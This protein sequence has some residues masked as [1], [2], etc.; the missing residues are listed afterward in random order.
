MAGG[1]SFRWHSAARSAS[2]LAL[3]KFGETP[4]ETSLIRE[5]VFKFKQPAFKTTEEFVRLVKEAEVKNINPERLRII[6]HEVVTYPKKETE[7]TKSHMVAED[8]GAAKRVGKTGVMV[9][10]VLTLIC[11]HPQH[12]DFGINVSYSQRYYPAQRDP[13]FLEK[14]T[15][16]FDSVDF[17]EF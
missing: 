11:I 17:V 3:G 12:K 4:E 6:K 15:T 8:H 2:Q 10:E 14:A 5:I 13:R 7:C 9:Q 16:V 1:L